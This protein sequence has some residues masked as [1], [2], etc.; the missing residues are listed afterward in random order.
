[1][2]ILSTEAKEKMYRTTDYDGFKRVIGNRRVLEERVSKILASFDK[3][4][5]IP[6]PIIVNENYEVIDGQ[7]RLEACK[8]RGYPVNYIVKP[9]LRIEDCI[10]MNI[11]ATPWKP[12]DYVECYAET[13]NSN[14][15]FIID[16]LGKLQ[17]EYGVKAVNLNNICTA[18]YSTKRAP[19]TAIKNGRLRV[20]KEMYDSAYDY[21]SFALSIMNYYKEN[22]VRLK[23]TDTADL[24][25]AIIFCAKF[26]EVDRKIFYRTLTESG[27]LMQKWN[28]LDSC[29]EQIDYIYNY[30]KKANRCNIKRLFE[31][32]TNKNDKLA[33]NF[34][35]YGTAFEPGSI[36]ENNEEE[37]EEDVDAI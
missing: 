23:C 9:G 24:L 10:I 11:N 18:L 19:G 20:T 3:I 12:L 7:G 25:T 15:Q 36:S 2:S 13:G 37:N 8:R 32:Y 6:V 14:Y 30:N 27:H 5:Y 21:L 16:L 31:D 17:M 33:S 29:I 28:N 22:N 34:V 26:D 1:M 35:T 4:G